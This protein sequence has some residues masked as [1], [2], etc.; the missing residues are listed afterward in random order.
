MFKEAREDNDLPKQRFMS[1][2]LF[3]TAH[4][5]DEDDTRKALAHMYDE[6]TDEPRF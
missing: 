5:L 4:D 3:C 1:I 2:R 6:T